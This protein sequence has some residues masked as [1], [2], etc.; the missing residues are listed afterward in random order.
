MKKIAVLVD[1]GFFRKRAVAIYGNLTPEELLK[2]LNNQC[3]GHVFPRTNKNSKYPNAN[4]KMSGN[5]LY[6]IFYYDCPPL[7]KK[8]THP[9]TN[10]TI[11]FSKSNSTAQTIEFLSLLKKQ[12]K[13]ALRLGKLSG[14]GSDYIMPA[15]NVKKFCSGE[16]TRDNIK[17]SDLTLSIRQKGVDMR[18]GLDI[19]S[20]SYK[21]QVDQI[22]LIAGDSDFVPA[23]K[24]AR[25]EG[26]DFI[27]DPMWNQI[28]PDLMEHIDGLYTSVEKPQ[29]LQ[30]QPKSRTNKGNESN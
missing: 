12:R 18:I 2:K 4:K 26:I 29:V 28:S 13:V 27:L 9:L 1:G 20:L 11:D 15:H 23:A 25:R 6:R 5:E 17:S 19:A 30:N 16:L 24:L 8:V 3:Y 7:E 22:V 10:K 21:K 14:N